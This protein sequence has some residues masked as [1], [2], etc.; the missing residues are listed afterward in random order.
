M[1]FRSDF[2]VGAR[3]MFLVPATEAAVHGAAKAHVSVS[4]AP[5]SDA[6]L[7]GMLEGLRMHPERTRNVSATSIRIAALGI[8]ADV[9]EPWLG[10]LARYQSACG[11]NLGAASAIAGFVAATAWQFTH[12]EHLTIGAIVVDMLEVLGTAILCAVLGKLA[13]LALARTR[14]Q[15]ATA[16]LIAYVSRP[17]AGA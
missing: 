2:R 12:F 16:I 13:G 1:K 6:S 4:S 17:A 7:L 10:E 15:R 8:P 11:C 14:F 5:R 9:R 3:M